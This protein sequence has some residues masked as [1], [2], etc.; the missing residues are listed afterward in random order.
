VKEGDG[1][2]LLLQELGQGILEQA[3]V[4]GDVCGHFGQCALQIKPSLVE[5]SLPNLD[6]DWYRR[7]V[8][9]APGRASIY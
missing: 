2:L 8:V 9:G 7:T 1:I 5:V 4:Q 3:F 6:V